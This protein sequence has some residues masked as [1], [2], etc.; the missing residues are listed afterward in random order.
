MREQGVVRAVRPGEADID[1]LPEPGGKCAECGA[2]ARAAGGAM[3][4][5]GVSDP[6]GVSVGD[7]VEVE[8]PIEARRRAQAAVF[9][10]PVAALLLGYLA[11]FLLGRWLGVDQDILGAV[12]ALTCGVAALLALRQAG[13]PGSVRDR[14]PVR[15]RAIIAEAMRPVHGAG[16]RPEDLSID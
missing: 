2:C 3:R 13:A 7:R 9:A 12:V 1:M 11:G 14:Y 15:I 5:D 8:V 16:E 4:L 10:G 6:I